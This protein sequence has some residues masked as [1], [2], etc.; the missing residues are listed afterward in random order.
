MRIGAGVGIAWVFIAALL[1]GYA[2][3]PALAPTIRSAMAEAGAATPPNTRFAVVI[4]DPAMEQ[5]VLDW[6]P[7][8][9]ARIS[10]GTYQGLEWTSVEKSD[11][12]VALDDRIQ[13]GQIPPDVDAI[14]QIK[15]GVASWRRIR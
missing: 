6:F 4:D 9:S 5:P 13:A 8:L 10:V 15:G 12:V 2:R 14:F 3:F 7:T 1:T 11:E